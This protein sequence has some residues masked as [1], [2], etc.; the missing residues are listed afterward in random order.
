MKLTSLIS[1][2]FIPPKN[3]MTT[4]EKIVASRAMGTTILSNISK[5]MS[6]ESIIL[7]MSSVYSFDVICISVFVLYMYHNYNDSTSKIS[8]FT[9]YS[10]VSKRTKQLI[11]IMFLIFTRDVENAI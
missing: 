1:S 6:F 3:T 9:V 10:N 8:G 2:A 7:K 11:F 4:L 5:E